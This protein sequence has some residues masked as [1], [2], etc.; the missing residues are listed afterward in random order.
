MF[1]LNDIGF[2]PFRSFMIWTVFAWP[3]IV[4]FMMTRVVTRARKIQLAVG[5]FGLLL[6]LEIITETFGLR[7]EPSFGELFQL[8]GSTMA[9]ATLIVVL[10]ANRAWRTVGLIALFAAILFVGAFI[11]SVLLLGC[12][13][14]V[15]K[16]GW[17]LTASPYLFGLVLLIT[18]LVTWLILRWSARRYQAKLSSDQLVTINGLWLL[19]TALQTVFELHAGLV[20]L[21]FLVSYAGYR[22]VLIIALRLLRVHTTA[23]PRPMLLL[24]VFG[25][26]RRA[27][28]LADQIGQTWRHTGCINMIGGTDLATSLIEPDELISFWSGKLRRNF[29]SGPADLHKR[30]QSLDE[31]PDPDGRYRINECFCHDN[32][33]RATVVALAQRSAVVLM[34]LR[35]FGKQNRGCEFELD[36]LLAEVPLSRIVLVIDTSTR[37]DELEMLLKSVWE[38]IP[39]SSPNDALAAPELMLFEAQKGERALRPLLSRLYAAAARDERTETDVAA[40]PMPAHSGA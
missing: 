12:A 23:T 35:G 17:L 3:I 15:T 16:D 29:I 38:K 30:L 6:V 19:C 21:W 9:P 27:R 36:M 37:I 8:W 18:A 7:Y 32:T 22:I 34:D 20:G 40:T 25:H 1:L 14:T 28:T 5:Y 13:T 24:R 31:H 4:V 33:W 26:G 11:V 39:H 10:L 2:R